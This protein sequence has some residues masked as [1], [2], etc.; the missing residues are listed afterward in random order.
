MVFRTNMWVLQKKKKIIIN[1]NNKIK[2][3][4]EKNFP[5][6]RRFPCMGSLCWRLGGPSQAAYLL[7]DFTDFSIQSEMSWVIAYSFIIIIIILYLVFIG[8]LVILSI[9]YR[10]LFAGMSVF[11]VALHAAFMFCL[12]WT[13]WTLKLW[14]LATFHLQMTQHV[15]AIPIYFPA[16]GTR[17][18]TRKF[19]Y[20][21]VFCMWLRTLITWAC[22]AL[23][24]VRTDRQ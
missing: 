19:I 18:Y 13:I 12:A 20:I 10:S 4:D 7:Q 24:T 21:A 11:Y 8:P 17:K 16:M 5:R 1:N 2:Y 6:L 14:F 22:Q 15:G 3:K 23:Y 9:A